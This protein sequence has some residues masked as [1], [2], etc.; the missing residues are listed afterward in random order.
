[1]FAMAQE[2]KNPNSEA[3]DEAEN[4]TIVSEVPWDI[5]YTVNEVV[6]RTTCF[7]LKQNNQ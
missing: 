7:L 3:Q 4:P 2:T 1:M 6:S 5:A